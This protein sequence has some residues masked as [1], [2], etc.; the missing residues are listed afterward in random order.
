MLENLTESELMSFKFEKSD[1]FKN[2]HPNIATY[3][4]TFVTHRIEAFD[5]FTQYV[6]NSD[7]SK[8]RDYCHG[9]LGVAASYRCFKLEE[10]LKYIQRYAREEQ[11]DPIKEVL[12][13]FEEYLKNLKNQV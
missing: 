7:F 6:D 4:N 8:I 11:I 9:Q 10:V 1:D 12:P 13:V 5:K 3:M 2:L